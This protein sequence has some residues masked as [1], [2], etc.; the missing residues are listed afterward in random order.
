MLLN[1]DISY[2]AEKQLDFVHWGSKVEGLWSVYCYQTF[3]VCLFSCF[4]FCFLFFQVFLFFSSSLFQGGLS[5]FN[6]GDEVNGMKMGP[7]RRL[8]KP[9]APHSN[10]SKLVTMSYVHEIFNLHQLK[11]ITRYEALLNVCYVTVTIVTWQLLLIY[12]NSKGGLTYT[13]TIC[14]NKLQI[15]TNNISSVGLLN[16]RLPLLITMYH[17]LKQPS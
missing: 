8:R 1:F 15:I 7:G 10:F 16:D 5:V 4:F 17:L 12:S 9:C 6:E 13:T 11:I 14:C 2:D 3:I